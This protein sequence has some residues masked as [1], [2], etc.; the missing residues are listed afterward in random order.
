MPYFHFP[1]KEGG[2]RRGSV[3]SNT[4]LIQQSSLNNI[5]T[6]NVTPIASKP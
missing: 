3:V 2:P 4:G 5:E 1:F 6:V